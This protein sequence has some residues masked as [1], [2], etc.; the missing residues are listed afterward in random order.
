MAGDIINLTYYEN[1]EVLQSAL[2]TGNASH[3]IAADQGAPESVLHAQN[4]EI[5]MAPDGTTVTSLTAR[6]Q[7]VLDLPGKSEKAIEERAVKRAGRQRGR[8]KGAH[9]CDIYGGC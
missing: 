4:V 6:D 2:V 9:G 8:R 7:V 5:A 3:R 1:T